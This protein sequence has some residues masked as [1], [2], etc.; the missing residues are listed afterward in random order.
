MD[1]YVLF[2]N[3]HHQPQEQWVFVGLPK[4]DI[5]DQSHGWLSDEHATYFPFVKEK[6]GIRVRAKMQPSSR[7]KL[8]ALPKERIPEAFR[9]H[10]SIQD[11]L[12]E[13]M[14][15][16]F[17]GEDQ[18][19]QPTV[20]LLDQSDASQHWVFRHFH[21][22]RRV[23]VDLF[24]TVEHD[25]PVVKW[26]VHAV[27]GT[28][29][30]NGQPQTTDI[31]ALRMESS[32]RMHP[33]FYERNGQNLAWWDSGIWKLILVR[34]GQRWHR[35]SRFE[36]RGILLCDGDNVRMANRPL[37]ALYGGWDGKWMALGKVPA[38]TVDANRVRKDQL[39][40]LTEPLWGSY[41]QQR[42]RI[43]QRESGTT[44]EQL[45]FGCAS[46]LGVVTMDPWEVYDALW[47][48][49]GYAQRPTA[50]REPGGRPMRA[51]LHPK[52][53]TMNQRPDL[54]LGVE[55]RLG[56]PGVNQIAWMPSPATVLWTTSD[57]QHR[58]DNFLHATIA[59][60]QDPAL[61][62][63]VRD[64]IELDKLDT[65]VRRE[66]MPSPRAVGRLALTRANQHW[67][68]F[69][70][71]EGTALALARSCARNGMFASQP[72]AKPVK[73]LGGFEEAKY[74][75]RTP[76]GG[77]VIGWQPWQETIAL[78]GLEALEKVGIPTG[79]PLLGFANTIVENA[80]RIAPNG[81]IH[82]YA[83]RWN[84]G[85]EFPDEKWPT[86]VATGGDVSNGDIYCSTACLYWTLAA[87]KY[88]ASF[89]NEFAINVLRQYGSPRS[90]TESRWRAL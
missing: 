55:D 75:W 70:G 34:E 58:A 10:K 33:D 48:C 74:G 71:A 20:E 31:P 22:T 30:N 81:I 4:D 23:S 6:G 54:N 56:W 69:E 37:C 51:D 43:Q 5:P 80:F 72:P 73:T 88:A 1:S 3:L 15:K 60:T 27:Y 8:F 26:T 86:F 44:G 21:P 2:E 87:A 12:T 28:T 25:D 90:V 46:D 67:L 77:P 83:V 79:L 57:D 63:I 52:A 59:L 84:D 42:P 40:A 18:F 35:A 64:H 36:S 38:L 53:E 89:G 62:A 19:P 14:P 47:Q 17:L 24:A 45:D 7:I 85:E 16:F 50:N 78:I 9:Y 76:E 29:E 13:I 66:R 82:A 41:D 49:Q 11:R 61:R 68:G 32:V 39:R 65:Y